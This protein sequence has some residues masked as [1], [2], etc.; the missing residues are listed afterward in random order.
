MEGRKPLE[1]LQSQ[2]RVIGMLYSKAFP[3]ARATRWIKEKP[4]TGHDVRRVSMAAKA[5]S[6]ASEERA[7]G[8]SPGKAPSGEGGG[9]PNKTAP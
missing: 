6:A 9:V 8:P 1:L 2:S 5:Q 3:V 4:P 7:G